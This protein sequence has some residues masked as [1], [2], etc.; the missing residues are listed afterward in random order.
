M[1]LNNGINKYYHGDHMVTTSIN[2]GP[3]DS[4]YILKL[5]FNHFAVSYNETSLNIYVT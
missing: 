3:V 1:A 2:N 5:S 4:F